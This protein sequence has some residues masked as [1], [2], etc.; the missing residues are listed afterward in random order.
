M[1]TPFI[2]REFPAPDVRPDA[3]VLW[4]EARQGRLMLKKCLDCGQ[5]HW[6]PRTLCPFCM[7]DTEWFA[8]SGLGS[9]Y[10]FSVSRRV[11]PTPFCIAYVTL[12]EG[13]S[14]MTNIVDCDL[15]AVRIGMPVRLVFKPAVNGQPVPLF[16]PV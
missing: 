15:D 12:A 9:V 8:A 10:T 2:D 14:M 11:G 4:E 6:Y 1:S 13:P 5:V 7:G 3:S 16:A